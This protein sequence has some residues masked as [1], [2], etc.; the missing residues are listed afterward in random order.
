M[1]ITFLIDDQKK[2]NPDTEKDRRQWQALR[3]K[4]RPGTRINFQI[5]VDRSTPQCRM[6]WAI[7]R[8][9]IFSSETVS[10]DFTNADDLHASKKWEFCAMRPEFFVETK[11]Y[12]NGK[13]EIGKI[14]FSYNMTSGVDSEG[15]NE[16]TNWALADFAQ[17]LGI[18]VEQLKMESEKHRKVD[19]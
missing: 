6:L 4:N 19:A 17:T 11:V 7:Y 8:F 16:Y 1:K 14:P 10:K 2:L 15:A 13:I 12:I 9:M 18:T 3:N 5:F